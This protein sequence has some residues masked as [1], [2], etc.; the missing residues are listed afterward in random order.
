VKA[1]RNPAELLT[2]LADHFDE[3]A[4]HAQELVAELRLGQAEQ[5]QARAE[6]MLQ[7]MQQSAAGMRAQSKQFRA[8]PSHVPVP[9][10][11]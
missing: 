5:A 3:L 7:S 4:S 8:K 11:K 2:M 10:R 9:W 6:A 1:P